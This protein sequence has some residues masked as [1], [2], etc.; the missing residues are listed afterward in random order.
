MQNHIDKFIASLLEEIKSNKLKLPTLPEVA[1]KV[2]ATV[3]D[4]DAPAAKIAKVVGMDAG[5]SARLLQVA[6]SPLFRGSQ[7]IESL[8]NAIARLGVP[9]VRSLVT[10]LLMQQLFQTKVPALRE[11][12]QRLWEHSA[13]VAAMSHVLARKFTSLKPDEAM[14]A[15]LI[16]DI[17]ALPILAK[18]E[19]YPEIMINPA[20]IDEVVDKLHTSVGRL[21][22][23]TWKFPPDLI[24]VTHQHE[25]LN[26][27]APGVDYV[28][29]VMVANLHSYIG[30]QHRHAK[31]NWAAVPAF[32][33]LGLT[34]DQSISALEEARA[35][36]AEVKSL[37]A[38]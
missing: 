18:L 29:I 2:R 32:Q 8:Q 5:L 34:P 20:A 12:M 28:D 37:L 38:A 30:T 33:R 26:R 15:G 35:E 3:N 24:A 6:N 19:N 27:E 7:K 23:E 21:I 31:A 25:D 17:G 4:A 16:H 9:Q 11:R 14:L 22:L 10:S 36:V 13:E 1:F